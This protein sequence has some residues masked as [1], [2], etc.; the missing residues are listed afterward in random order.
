MPRRKKI[1][2]SYRR[3]DTAGHIGR[4]HDDLVRAFGEDRVF[5]DIEGLHPGDEFGAVLR[6]RLAE[7]LVVIVAIGPRWMGAMDD[8][9]RRIDQPNDF[10]RLEVATALSEPQVRVIPVLCDGAPLPT[11]DTLPPTITALISRQAFTLSDQRWRHDVQQLLDAIAPYVPF[12]DR[13]KRVAR[14]VALAV[15]AL[16]V[17]AVG[18]L[19]AFDAVRTKW[20]A[21]VH[22]EGRESSSSTTPRSAPSSSRANNAPSDATVPTA[23]ALH[24]LPPR[25]VS[26]AAQQLARARREWSDDAELSAIEISCNDSRRL[27]CPV[28][29]KLSSASRVASLEAMRVAPDS[30]WRYRQ[31]GGASRT[32]ALSLEIGELDQVVAAARAAGVTSDFERVNLQWTSLQNG[33]SA[34][35]WV[36]WPRNRDQAGR[37][38]RLCFEPQS[39]TRVDCRTGQ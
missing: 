18:G 13:A 3:D 22:S 10:V 9:R 31:S 20:N 8:G 39:T 26:A 19:Y 27:D 7:S 37:E 35:R 14:R 6:Q 32:P 16:A 12:K 17:I 25:V 5:W 23:P 38:G 21:V 11:V 34:P 1:F 15:A 29:L 4:L 30:A 24:V 2:L 28:K 33:T 36:L